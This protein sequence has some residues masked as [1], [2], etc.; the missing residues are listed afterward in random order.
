MLVDGF[1]SHTVFHALYQMAALRIERHYQVLFLLL[2]NA[3]L[4]TLVHTAH[5]VV[6]S[7]LRL[8]V[9]GE[10]TRIEAVPHAEIVGSH[11]LIIERPCLIPAITVMTHV[12]VQ[13]PTGIGAQ[14]IIAGIE[15]VAQ[16]ELSA[17]IALGVDDNILA[18]HD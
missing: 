10:H 2:G 9:N 6:A 4:R 15:R 11:L 3:G 17:G 1:E 18:L 14:L 7:L 8:T 5:V 16:R 12:E 13:H